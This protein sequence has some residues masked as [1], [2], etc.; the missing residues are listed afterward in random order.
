[1]SVALKK[2]RERV[3]VDSDVLLPEDEAVTR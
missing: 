2:L 1:V 3:G